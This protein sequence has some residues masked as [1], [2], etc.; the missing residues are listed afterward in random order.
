MDIKIYKNRQTVVLGNICRWDGRLIPDPLAPQMEKQKLCNSE[1]EFFAFSSLVFVKIS[2]CLVI[3]PQD[4]LDHH[5][6]LVLLDEDEDQLGKT[7]KLT[8]SYDGNITNDHIFYRDRV[9]IHPLKNL[10]LIKSAFHNN[11]LNSVTVL[12]C[13]RAV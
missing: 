7:L 12:M 6:F 5:V 13:L 2:F 8:K 3:T 4:A 10:K 11:L 9:S 1:C